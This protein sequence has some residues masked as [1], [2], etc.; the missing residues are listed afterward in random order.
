MA[1]KYLKKIA[2]AH[3]DAIETAIQS[4]ELSASTIHDLKVLSEVIAKAPKDTM[5]S[6]RTPAG[7]FIKYIIPKLEQAIEGHT[8][9][10]EGIR[11][12][13]LDL[14]DP[15]I[16]NST[17][18]ELINI[19]RRLMVCEK[20]LKTRIL[21]VRYQRGLLYKR[22]HQLIT[23][24]EQLKQWLMDNFTVSYST[25]TAYMSVASIIQEFPLLLKCDLSFEQLRRHKARLYQYFET[26]PGFDEQ[27]DIVQ[28]ANVISVLA[29]PYVVRVTDSA[30]KDADFE[31]TI[32]EDEKPAD[33][34]FFDDL[35]VEAHYD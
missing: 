29:D 16:Q 31:S 7:D 26:H 4:V 11:L 8:N 17:L 6:K 20:D 15:D 9:H 25:V 24:F 2:S 5:T 3:P 33:F 10:P 32:V 22:A 1:A 18:G 21:V 14:E 19:H 34:P 30:S 23:D 35:T 12:S 28:G 13:L 27:C